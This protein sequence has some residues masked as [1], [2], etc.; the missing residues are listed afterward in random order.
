MDNQFILGAGG[1][2]LLGVP[3]LP[4]KSREK[5][6]P[7]ISAATKDLLDTWNCTDSVAGM[8][9]DTTRSNT[10]VI[11]GACISIL[12]ALDLPLLWFACRHHVREV[13]LTHVW[14]LL[15]HHKFGS[16]K[17]NSTFSP[18]YNKKNCGL[19]ISQIL[20]L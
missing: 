2:K 15:A 10:G 5:V 12:T 3:K 11:S 13:L 6:W 17:G 8:V 19:L 1:V 9:F 16:L 7:H 14:R 18:E 4:H 20:N